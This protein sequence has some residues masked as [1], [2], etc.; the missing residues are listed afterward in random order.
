MKL[1]YDM[2][3]EREPQAQPPTAIILRI[4]EDNSMLKFYGA[5]YR[6]KKRKAFG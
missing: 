2:F 1:I 3:V 6:Y 4:V 5:D